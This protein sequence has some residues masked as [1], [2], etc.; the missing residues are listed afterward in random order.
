MLLR[1]LTTLELQDQV[2]HNPF[3]LGCQRNWESVFGPHMWLWFVP[4]STGSGDGHQWQVEWAAPAEQEL[5]AVV[6][7]A[8]GG[9]QGAHAL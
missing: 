5:Q 3:N 8:M 4:I 7:G 2:G 9:A 6:Q 1:N